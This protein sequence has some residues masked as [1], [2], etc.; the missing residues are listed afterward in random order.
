MIINIHH[1]INKKNKQATEI[2]WNSLLN[3]SF[4]V[5]KKAVHLF[6]VRQYFKDFID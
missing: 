2:F 3:S 5:K 4:E 6:I 1:K